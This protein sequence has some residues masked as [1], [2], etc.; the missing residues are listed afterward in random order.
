[1]GYSNIK[2]AGANETSQPMR[3]GTD[4]TISKNP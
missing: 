2:K 3:N 1:M 4:L